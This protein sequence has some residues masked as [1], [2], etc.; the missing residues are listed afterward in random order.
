MTNK[1]TDT[2]NKKITSFYANSRG[3]VTYVFFFFIDASK[4]LVLCSLD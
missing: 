2:W 3:Q 4:L 1:C